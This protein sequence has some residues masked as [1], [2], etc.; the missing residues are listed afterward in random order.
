MPVEAEVEPVEGMYGAGSSPPAWS[1]SSVLRGMS[2]LAAG[3]VPVVDAVGTARPAGVHGNASGGVHVAKAYGSQP[4]VHGDT[5][6]VSVVQAVAGTVPWATTARSDSRMC[7]SSRVTV[8][9]PRRRRLR[10][11]DDRSGSSHARHA[12]R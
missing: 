9:G 3:G 2:P 7:P 4:I 1:W 11:P 12:A 6:P 10:G 8:T 5:V